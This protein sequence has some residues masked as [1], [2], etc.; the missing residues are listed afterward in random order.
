MKKLSIVL[1]LIMALSCFSLTAFAADEST[2]EAA[3]TTEGRTEMRRQKSVRQLLEKDPG[4]LSP[5]RA[6]FHSSVCFH[7]PRVY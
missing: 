2:T 3:A 1:A 4:A 5:S 6:S 7:Y